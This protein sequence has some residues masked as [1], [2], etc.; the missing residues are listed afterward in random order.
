MKRRKNRRRLTLTSFPT[1][2]I[3]LVVACMLT[4]G[5][6]AAAADVARETILR[7]H[8]SNTIGAKLAPALAAAFLKNKLGA[9]RVDMVPRRANEVLVEGLFTDKIMAVEIQAHGSSTAFKGLKAFRCDIGMAS[10]RIKPKEIGE[11][12]FLGDMTSF[13]CEYVLG[14][15]GIAVIV[16]QDNPI[17]SLPISRI[18]DIFTGAVTDWGQIDATLS[19]PVT[20]FARD[21]KSGTFDTF[22]HLVLGKTPL[23]RTARR[24]ESNAELSRA[25]SSEPLAI[26]FTGLPYVLRAKALAVSAGDAPAVFPTAHTIATE[27]YPLSRRLHLYTPMFPENVYTRFFVDFALS[28]EG[29]EIVEKMEFI[30]QNVKT[31][32]MTA[33]Q[34]Q[35]VQDLQTFQAYLDAVSGARRVS[36]NFHFRSGR[37]ELDAK[38][39]QNLRRI[40]SFLRR[41]DANAGKI[42][43]V[44][45]ADSV[46]DYAANCRIALNRA[47]SVA[48]SLMTRG[49]SLPMDVISAGEEAPVASNRTASGREKNRRVEMW[50]K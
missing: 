7:I 35:P 49:I 12:S 22:K 23:T 19:G 29:Q 11:L 15:D 48:E 42:I 13:A 25:V 3:A 26:G 14:L 24:F 30:D 9:H 40:V 2:V 4:W 1:A 32:D 46:G 33:A 37:A 45:F 16:H 44:G 28:R 31:F 36:V 47:R 17:S 5:A 41:G 34:D 21:D 38:S 27:D 39:V 18:A 50:I 10:R 43:L 6:S 8:G 20:V